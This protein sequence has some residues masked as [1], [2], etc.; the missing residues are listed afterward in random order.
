MEDRS[1]DAAPKPDL[2]HPFSARR[3]CAFID[4]VKL[5]PADDR[6]RDP[7]KRPAADECGDREYQCD[8]RFLTGACRGSRLADHRRCSPG[9]RSGKRCGTIQAEHCFGNVG[10]F[11]LGTDL[12]HAILTERKDEYRRRARRANDRLVSQLLPLNAAKRSNM[13]Q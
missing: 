8:R 12:G 9:R 7:G 10:L 13:R 3:R 6:R 5:H 4:R 2:R 11:T 1:Y